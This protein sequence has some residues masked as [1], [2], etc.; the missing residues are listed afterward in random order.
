MLSS[1][2]VSSTHPIWISVDK[3][4]DYL[5][6]NQ[7][8]NPIWCQSA[9]YFPVIT[10][11]LNPLTN[12]N[13]NCLLT[14]WECNTS[15]PGCQTFD[16]IL[17]LSFLFR[18]CWMPFAMLTLWNASKLS[19]LLFLISDIVIFNADGLWKWYMLVQLNPS[20]AGPLH[21]LAQNW[22]SVWLQMSWSPNSARPS[23]GTMLNIKLDMNHS[24]F[25]A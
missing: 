8:S 23:A 11:P 10:H 1:N 24:D 5:P 2:H 25:S 16:P 18:A 7:T 9:V 12:A 20:T 13:T 21:I 15:F 3:P 6:C 4:A 17:M 14:Q 19:P 22:S